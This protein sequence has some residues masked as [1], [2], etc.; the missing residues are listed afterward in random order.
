[1]TL[2]GEARLL[3]WHAAHGG[4]L[5]RIAVSR[6]APVGTQLGWRPLLPVTQLVAIK[7]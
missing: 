4:E 2:A 6:A 7:S 5:V 1:V 3:A